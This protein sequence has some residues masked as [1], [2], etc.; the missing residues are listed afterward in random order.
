MDINEKMKVNCLME[1][2]TKQ[3]VSVQSKRLLVPTTG[4]LLRTMVTTPGIRIC[5]LGI[6][7]TTTTRITATT[8]VLCGD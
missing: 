6:R 3:C 7:T 1:H 4:R 8:C 5:P 2:S